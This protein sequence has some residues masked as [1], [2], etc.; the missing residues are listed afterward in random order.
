M[1]V[2]NKKKCS[3]K[4][5]YI[6]DIYNDLYP[7]NVIKQRNLSINKVN[8]SLKEN[9]NLS[10]LENAKKFIEGFA[11]IP[12][13]NTKNKKSIIEKLKLIENTA[14]TYLDQLS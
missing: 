3:K 14:R 11:G 7:Y 6:G 2:S 4:Y 10:I 9:N 1:N 13:N 8:K 12:M 5:F